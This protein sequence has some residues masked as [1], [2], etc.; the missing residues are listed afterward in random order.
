M[1]KKLVLA[2]P[3]LCIHLIANAQ[4]NDTINSYISVS[5]TGNF[6][7]T[8]EVRSSL[9]SNIL[10]FK[11]RTKHIA[12]NTTLKYIYGK[13][14]AAT[15]NNDFYGVQ[16]LNRYIKSQRFYAWVLAS[17]G[18]IYSLGIRHQFQAGP[19]LAYTILQKSYLSFNI[20]DGILY[21]YR[22]LR[23]EKLSNLKDQAIRNSLRLQVKANIKEAVT[24]TSTLFL[25]NSLSDSRDAII[26]EET[27]LA[28]R[29]YRVLSVAM[30]IQYNMLTST[31]KETLLVTWGL[32]YKSYF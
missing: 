22:E 15:V 21:E 16:E 28:V 4:F 20:S 10:E 11:R 12:A 9:S 23:D 18:Q 32:T 26:R 13:Q 14:N 2:V 3:A 5:A 6:N 30:K 7:R 17:Y 8:N 1:K 25:Q 29:I 24:L 27:E 19:G 31:Q